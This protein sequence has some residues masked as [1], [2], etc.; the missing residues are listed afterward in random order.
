MAAEHFVEAAHVLAL[1]HAVVER[2][3]PDRTGIGGAGGTNG[4]R[5]DIGSDER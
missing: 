5:H 2:E 4:G 3:A 1:E